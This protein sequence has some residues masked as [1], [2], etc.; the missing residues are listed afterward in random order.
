MSA[1]SK[2]RRIVCL[3]IAIAISIVVAAMAFFRHD[4][5]EK[6]EL[7][8]L[9]VFYD[10]RGSLEPSPKIVIA[11]IDDKSLEE[12]GG[13]PWKRKVFSNLL[14]R[15]RKSGATTI[16]IDT[17]F[18]QDI[19][20]GDRRLLTMI[21]RKKDAVLGYAFYPLREDIPLD[22]RAWATGENSYDILAGQR[23]ASTSR[24]SIELPS[25]AGVRAIPK[26]L[27]LKGGLLAFTNFLGVQKRPLT[28]APLVARYKNLLLP[29]LGLS[30]ASRHS[31]FT[32]L[33]R[34]DARGRLTAVTIGER[35]MPIDSS[36]RVFM[37]FAGPAGT[38]RHLSVVD[39]LNEKVDAESLEGS[40]VLVGPTFRGPQIRVST[41]Y[42][43]DIPAIE[44]WANVVDNI[45]FGRPLVSAFS[46][47][48]VTMSIVLVLG[49]VL[50]LVLPLMRVLY[51]FAIA[52]G[53]SVAVSIEGY[54]FLT[55]FGVW[56]PVATPL[57]AVVAVFLSISAYRLVTEERYRRRMRMRFGSSLRKKN[58]EYFAFNPQELP[59][60]GERHHLTVL[61]VGIRNFAA[62]FEEVPP[63]RLV[64]FI[65]EYVRAVSQELKSE[66]AFTVFAGNEKIVAIFGAPVRRADHAMRACRAALAIRKL[67]AKKRQAWKEKYAFSTLRIGMGIHTGPLVVG[68]IG[69]LGKDGFSALGPAVS[70]SERFASLDRVYH[71]TIIASDETVRSSREW[72]AFRP[73]DLVR[74]PSMKR[75]V[76]IHELLGSKNVVTPYLEMYKQ[77]YEAYREKRFDQ[78]VALAEGVLA[79][80]P[81]DGP[82]LILRARAKKFL[83][84]PPGDKW[85][86]VWVVQE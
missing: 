30:V 32:P 41:P 44:L 10:A 33:V 62:L 25:M 27:R 20:G 75:P 65:R 34:R 64:S 14:S 80:L 49:I 29:S 73:L 77:A 15:L 16:A 72:C 70:L 45:V 48:A 52:I 69:F 43:D 19:I 6:S 47:K 84:H 78:A 76:E 11:A 18:A 26:S 66:D 28:S 79:K 53:L 55:K 21:E 31:R 83:E 82:S 24:P 1:V 9:R 86:G 54:F 37:D 61:T 23:I 38:Y 7:G 68:E 12:L 71:T 13:W 51:S 2:K 60:E 42:G 17:T 35:A 67:A 58:L 4:L 50:G 22:K 81:H 8:I 59:R 39:I 74:F 85:D 46:S 57:F 3:Q 63:K 36:G 56:F 40:I 5:V